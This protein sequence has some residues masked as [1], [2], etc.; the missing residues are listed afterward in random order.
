M[1][2]AKVYAKNINYN[3]LV[4]LL[5][6]HIVKW[7]SDKDSFFYDIFAKMISNK[8]KP[9]K[10]SKLL[11]SVIP[12]KTDMA[13]TILPHFDDVLLEYLNSLL[14]QN[15]IVA[16]IISIKTDTLE[17]NHETLLK[18]E[19]NADEIDYEKT[20]EY[21]LPI[22]LQKLSEQE[23]KSGRLAKLILGL[24]E[25]PTQVI[26]AAVGAIPSEQR[27]DLAVAFLTEYKIELK[28]MVNTIITNN[29]VKA[30]ISAIKIDSI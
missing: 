2:R 26:K 16:K 5:M 4:E 6:P 30:E 13:A 20:M 11:V 24:N 7:L 23:E 15:N 29:N 22:I 18:I 9:T 10:F 21:K 8:G 19:I 25:L 1:I 27:D 14:V 17:R 3:T 12:N 28:E